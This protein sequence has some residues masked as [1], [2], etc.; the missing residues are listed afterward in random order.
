MCIYIGDCGIGKEGNLLSTIVCLKTKQTDILNRILELKEADENTYEFCLKNL[1]RNFTIKIALFGNHHEPQEI[2]QRVLKH[3]LEEEKAEGEIYV[4]PA[5]SQWH[6]K[7][8]RK[9]VNEISPN[10]IRTATTQSNAGMKLAASIA[11]IVEKFYCGS[12][13]KNVKEIMNEL[14]KRK[15][16]DSQ[17][18]F[19]D[20]LIMQ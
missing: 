18:I 16:I 20:P 11:Q 9:I 17:F 19:G 10:K 7:Y 5:N 8:I 12:A 15:K 13:D 3:L 6:K 4:D 2:I 1:D 14:K